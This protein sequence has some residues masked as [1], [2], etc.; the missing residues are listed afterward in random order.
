MLGRKA[1]GTVAYLG[2]VPAMLEAFT[3]SWGQMVQYNQELFA[4]DPG[5]V[6]YDRATISDHAP[7]RNGLVARFIGDWLVQFDTDHVFDPDIVARLVRTADEY[8]LDVLSAVYQMKQAPHVPVLFQ[9]AEV[10]GKP[11]LQPLATW[12]DGVRVLQ[13]GSAGAGCLFVR[14]SVFD[15]LSEAYHGVGAFDKIHPFS[16]DHSFF[17]RCKEQGIHCYAAM[18][19]HSHH[20]RV[21][22]VTLDDLDGQ[23]LQVSP[24]FA[25]EGFR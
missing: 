23:G 2:G 22:P 12:P 6:H 10:S 4:D 14:R 5:Y 3:W 19:I 13:I 21:A 25:V 9:W 1:L 24:Q 16:E 15:R 20:L 18:Q 17:L 8:G 7:A 11:G